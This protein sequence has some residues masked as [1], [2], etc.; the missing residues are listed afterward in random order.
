MFSKIL[1]RVNPTTTVA[2]IFIP[3]LEQIIEEVK[4]EVEEEV[5]KDKTSE[6]PKKPIKPVFRT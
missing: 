2:P 5:K 3:K 4:E 1:K 6:Q